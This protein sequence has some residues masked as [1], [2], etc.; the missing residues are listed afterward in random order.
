MP[1]ALGPFTVPDRRGPGQRPAHE[2]EQR[3]AEEKLNRDYLIDNDPFRSFGKFAGRWVV[4]GIDGTFHLMPRHSMMGLT[5]SQPAY[6][7]AL[8]YMLMPEFDFPP[9]PEVSR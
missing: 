5:S 8:P 1:F 2:W 3:W 6:V 7:L 9:T 4:Q